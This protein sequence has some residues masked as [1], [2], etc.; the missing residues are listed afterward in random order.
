[1]CPPVA[2]E[3]IKNL[4][5]SVNERGST[6]G[7]TLHAAYKQLT[8]IIEEN[9]EDND[10]SETDIIIADGHK[11]R[12]N[13][14]VMEHCDENSLGQFILPPDTSGVTQKHDQI[15]QLLHSNYESKK[16][17]LYSEYSDLDRKVS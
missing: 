3:K 8:A 12:F 16:S 6:T 5:I 1:M 2:A 11:S 9:K 10:G 14:R 4:L 13:P 7:E 15:N 17:E